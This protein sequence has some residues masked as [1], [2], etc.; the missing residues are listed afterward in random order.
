MIFRQ[1]WLYCALAGRRRNR[2]RNRQVAQPSAASRRRCSRSH[3]DEAGVAARPRS[4]GTPR[5]PP[6]ASWP[7]GFGA[8]G[9]RASG[10]PRRDSIPR[11]G[12]RGTAGAIKTGP[13]RHVSP[14]Q[15][16]VC[17]DAAHQST[18]T[19]RTAGSASRSGHVIRLS[20]RGA[21][22]RRLD[23]HTASTGGKASISERSRELREPGQAVPSAVR[24]TTW[25]TWRGQSRAGLDADAAA[26]GAPTER[27]PGAAVPMS[28]RQPPSQCQLAG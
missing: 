15:L 20:A 2:R 23:E 3:L 24:A 28:G 11:A 4:R 10:C 9:S 7:A 25:P 22:I 19:A 8:F 21:G 14:R 5:R 18:C 1:S 16:V 13:E 12:R 17:E 27:T 6:R 26:P